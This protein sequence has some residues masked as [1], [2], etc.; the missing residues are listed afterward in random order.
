[1]AT[2]FISYASADE[3]IALALKTFLE[4]EGVSTYFA[5]VE[6]RPGRFG[7]QLANEIQAAQA[8]VVVASAAT[9]EETWVDE[10]LAH[11]RA[12][13]KEI[14]PIIVGPYDNVPL[15]L[16][17]LINPLQRYFFN[18]ASERPFQRISE[19]LRLLRNRGRIISV[20][21]MRGG[22]GK[23]ILT[24]NLSTAVHARDN[25]PTL[26]V[27]FDPQ[28]NL[29]Q[30]FFSQQRKEEFWKRNLS[31]ATLLAEEDKVFPT[32]FASL[33][34][35]SSGAAPLELIPGTDMLLEYTLG[36]QDPIALERAKAAFS[37]RLGALRDRYRVIVIDLN[38]AATFLTRCALEC[39]DHV[40]VPVRPEQFS[41]VGLNL[42]AKLI[43]YQ[44]RSSQAPAIP[45]GFT[46]ILNGVGD[47]E[48]ASAD[49]GVDDRI[50][51]SIANFPTWGRTLCPTDLPKNRFLRASASTIPL[52]PIGVTAYYRRY[53]PSMLKELLYSVGRFAFDRAGVLHAP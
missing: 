19:A 17:F 13:H 36:L 47:K 41:P 32:G 10:E 23:T 53:S 12:H 7:K 38:P 1:M 20:L 40:I 22:V 33:L 45:E 34:P 16:R 11:A 48:V 9:T 5:P 26:L 3:K 21:N 31:V 43:D 37:Q 50:R 18:S 52:D 4:R 2:I 28:H 42:L 6:A 24:A 30:L 35:A 51:R 25:L 15:W 39:S 14:I 29:T 8:V 27:D 46:T 49:A 44:K